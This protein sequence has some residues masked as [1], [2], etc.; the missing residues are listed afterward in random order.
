[1][2]ITVSRSSLLIGFL[3]LWTLWRELGL[4][5]GCSVRENVTKKVNIAKMDKENKDN[6]ELERYDTISAVQKTK[7]TMGEDHGL[8][9]TALIKTASPKKK[10][11][12]GS[13]Q[14]TSSFSIDP[15]RPRLFLSPPG[16]VGSTATWT[17][18]G[19]ILEHHGVHVQWD[20]NY[21]F[22]KP[23][24]NIFYQ[25][26]AAERNDNSSTVDEDIL[27]ESVVRM[28]KEAQTKKKTLLLKLAPEFPN[29][30]RRLEQELG[31]V[32]SAIHR[33]NFLDICACFAR[34]CFDA[35]VGYPVFENGTK[36]DNICIA[37]RSRDDV[38]TLAWLKAPVKCIK[39]R[40]RDDK[41]VLDLANSMETPPSNVTST[42]AL[43]AFE[44]T[45]D[46]KVFD[47]SVKFASSFMESFLGSDL[48]HTIIRDIF[49]ELQNSRSPPG[50]HKNVIYNMDEVEEALVQAEEP[51][52]KFIRYPE[53]SDVELINSTS[54][55]H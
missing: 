38:V 8:V 42:E 24:K 20:Q 34:D 32:F 51:F 25:Q 15:S 17:I 54:P 11:H 36:A 37:R 48:D 9:N 31:A 23:N 49:E 19:K 52:E 13:I 12:D 45:D 29:L 4:T 7:N 33:E 26:I 21:E 40:A 1:M 5:G 50:S 10:S 22:Y 27:F 2:S 35:D 18:T 28:Q 44:Y 55:P 46:V 30:A 41:K 16:C 43:F 3:L 47:A 14:E 39:H 6:N 53:T